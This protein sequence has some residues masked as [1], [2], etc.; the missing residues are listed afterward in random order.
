MIA[1]RKALLLGILLVCSPLLLLDGP[2]LAATT[3]RPDRVVVAAGAPA[4]AIIDA[5]LRYRDAIVEYRR[6]QAAFSPTEFDVRFASVATGSQY[7]YLL[8]AFQASRARGKT[9]RSV[10]PR[11]VAAKVVLFDGDRAVV[12]ACGDITEDIVDNTTKARSSPEQALRIA[13]LRLDAGVWK[14]SLETSGL[15]RCDWRSTTVDR[16]RRSRA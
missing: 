4:P 3:P 6:A 1:T 7:D 5:Y 14:V 11:R 2:K 15:G 13:V 16:G 12:E 9:F 10:P 8:E